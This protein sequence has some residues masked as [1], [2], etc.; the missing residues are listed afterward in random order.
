MIQRFASQE[1]A[2]HS[3]QDQLKLVTYLFQRTQNTAV[4][5][6]VPAEEVPPVVLEYAKDML[7]AR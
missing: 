3:L 2:I 1:A 4:P 5:V 7:F 6:N